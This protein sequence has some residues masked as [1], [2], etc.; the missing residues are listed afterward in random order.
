MYM[1]HVKIAFCPSKH[2]MHASHPI[3]LNHHSDRNSYP[4]LS[5]TMNT[6]I[7]LISPE[8]IET[9]SS[10]YPPILVIQPDIAHADSRTSHLKTTTTAKRKT[11]TLPA[12]RL[13]SLRSPVLENLS[14]SP[15]PQ[16]R[17]KPMA[18]FLHSTRG[19]VGSPF[20]GQRRTGGE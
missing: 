12:Q 5:T 11:T 7:M 6:G 3:D 1:V 19:I 4:L 16:P 9:A 14:P 17:K 2:K 8:R 15:R 18:T 10:P 20:T 13:P